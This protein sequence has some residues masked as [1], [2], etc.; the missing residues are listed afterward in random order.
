[1]KKDNGR[2]TGTRN[3]FGYCPGMFTVAQAKDLSALQR[4]PLNYLDSD[5]DW[6]P[7]TDSALP[8]PAVFFGTAD[9]AKFDENTKLSGGNSAD[10][11]SD[12]KLRTIFI[13]SLKT[14]VFHLRQIATLTLL[15]R[16]RLWTD[17]F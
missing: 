3:A 16:D 5:S 17:M 9:A 11:I 7:A 6:K 13:S 4:I 12:A 15:I 2:N 10:P 8:S 14:R 1:M